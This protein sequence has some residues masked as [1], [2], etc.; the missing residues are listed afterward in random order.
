MGAMHWLGGGGGSQVPMGAACVCWA[1][2]TLRMPDPHLFSE[3]SRLCAP[4]LKL[5]KNLEVANLVWAFAKLGEKGQGPTD[6]FNA[7]A[8]E[9][10]ART[11]DFTVVNL[12]TLAW[13][14]ATSRVRHK[15]FFKMVAR[16]VTE[17][18]EKA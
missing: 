15:Q 5:F 17:S 1:H 14:F 4:H 7:A 8:S 6:L 18:A 13:A 9:A 2:A 16:R 11:G 10:M 12:S 3:V